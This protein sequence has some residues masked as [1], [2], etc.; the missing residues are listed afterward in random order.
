M[1]GIMILVH[2][3]GHF[4]TAKKAG[5]RVDEFAIGFGPSIIKWKRR[6]T[7]YSLKL[8]PVG[9]YVKL[10][11]E[12]EDT[13]DGT[14]FN[15]KPIWKRMLVLFAGAF[16]NLLSAFVVAVLLVCLTPALA[17]N[18]V[19]QFDMEQS[20]PEESGLRVGDEIVKVNGQTIHIASDLPVALLADDDGVVDM[21]VRRN[22]QVVL[23]EGVSFRT[24]GEGVE[25]EVFLDLKFQRAAKTPITVLRHSF[26]RCV[27]ITK[28]IWNSLLDLAQGKIGVEALSGVVGTTQAMGQIIRAGLEPMLMIFIFISINLGIFNL[29][30]I[31]ALDGGRIVFLIVEAIRGKPVKREI[32]GIVNA[33]GFVLLIALMVFVTYHDVL[34]IF[35]K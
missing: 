18:T 19:A 6:E 10:G 13:F 34:R 28:S 29:L 31:P 1:F 8:L 15:E 4:I 17:S 5:I 16:M 2:E 21:Q 23:L 27:S 7:Q 14:G 22:G 25:R 9:G 26:F 33:I 3:F 20:L 35:A 32:E 11:G 12:D 30:P 24:Q